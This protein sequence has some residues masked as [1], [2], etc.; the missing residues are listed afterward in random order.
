MN[1][2]EQYMKRALQLAALG[3]GNVSP[4]PLVGAVIVHNGKIIGEGYH[5]QWGKAHAEVN[6]VN[7][8]C[9]RELLPES[10]IYVTLEPC[11][12]FGKTP[13]CARLLISCGFKRVV[14]GTLDP[15]PAVSGKG[16]AMLRE[17]G[18]DVTVGTLENECKLINRRFIKAHTT[19]I[20]WVLLK[21]AQSTDGFIASKQGKTTFSTTAT[22]SLMHRERALCDAIVVGA[23][24]VITDDPA[25]STRFWSGRDPLRVVLDANLSAPHNRKVFSDG[26]PTLVINTKISNKTGSVEHVVLDNTSPLSWLKLLYNRG[27]TSVMVEG[28]ANVLQQLIYDDLWDEARIETSPTILGDGLKAPTINATIVTNEKHCENTVT[29]LRNHVKK[30]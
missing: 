4:N 5:R 7:S 1:H 27:I 28:G 25:L 19:G 26:N 20:P 12:H 17:A 2:D 16:V 11:S 23:R 22:L 8:V 24:T 10:T 14:V 29:I 6:A 18:I 15:F 13:P 21:W 3:E 30:V 9:Q